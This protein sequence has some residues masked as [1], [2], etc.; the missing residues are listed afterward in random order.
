MTTNID[1]A[2]DTLI[3]EAIQLGA[4]TPGATGT[5]FTSSSGA[6]TFAGSIT[7]TGGIAAAGGFAV[8]PRNWH[9]GGS[10]AQASTDFTDQTVVITEVYIAE[11]YVPANCTLT[12]AAIF[13]GSAAANNCKVGLANSA[14]VVVATSASTAHTG[15]DQ[16][17]RVPFTST[18]A[19]VGPATYY[20]LTFYDTAAAQANAHTVGNFGA[21]K[22]TGQVYATGFTTITPPTTFTTALGPV[23]S[24]Y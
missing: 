23:A 7:P 14:G 22:Q 9:T 3:V 13:N 19:A 17:Q 5:A 6:A 2:G 15:N 1:M 10:P 21:S 12:G 8:S 11:V 16:Y 18:Y 24:L 20:V 4:T